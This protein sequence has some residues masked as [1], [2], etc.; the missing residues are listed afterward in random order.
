MFC[1]QPQLLGAVQEILI[2]SEYTG[3]ER[4]TIRFAERLTLPLRRPMPVW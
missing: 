3:T 2:L 1:F 4:S